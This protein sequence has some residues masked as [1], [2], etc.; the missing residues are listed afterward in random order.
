MVSAS[1]ARRNAILQTLSAAVV[2]A[3]VI[4]S[5]AAVGQVKKNS[6]GDVEHHRW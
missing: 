2:L 3:A 6:H 5:V 4:M 1:V